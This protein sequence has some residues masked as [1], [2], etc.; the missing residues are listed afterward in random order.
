MNWVRKSVILFFAGRRAEREERNTV[1]YYLERKAVK[2]DG[3]EPVIKTK[4]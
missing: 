2:D 3:C 4:P 1:P